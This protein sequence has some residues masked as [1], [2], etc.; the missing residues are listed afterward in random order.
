MTLAQWVMDLH[1][2]GRAL[3]APTAK[4]LIE[5]ESVASMTA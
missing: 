5:I 4:R 2:D 1:E 3:C